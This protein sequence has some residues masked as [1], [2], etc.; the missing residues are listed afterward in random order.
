[1]VTAAAFPSIFPQVPKMRAF[2]RGKGQLGIALDERRNC[3]IGTKGADNTAI[4][5]EI[6]ARLNRF[7]GTLKGTGN[8]VCSF[9][10]AGI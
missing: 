6:L 1:M 5:T 4:H 3:V 7:L 10:G 9:V 2:K 8:E